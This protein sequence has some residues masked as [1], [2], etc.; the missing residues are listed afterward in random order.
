MIW[1]FT[2]YFLP[3][4]VSAAISSAIAVYSWRYRSSPGS[5]SL[6]FLMTAAAIW[7][8]AYAMELGSAQLSLKLFFTGIEYIGIVSLPLAWLVLS[9]EF[10]GRDS[11]ISYRRI[12][13]LAVIP[14]ITILLVWTNDYHHLIYEKTW[15]DSNFGYPL[16]DFVQGSWYW[17]N[18]VY[19]YALI[20]IATLLVIQSFIQSPRIYKN[21]ALVLLLGAL[22]PW[23]ANLAY[24]MG[25]HVLPFLD[26]TPIAF[27]L[28]GIFAAIGLFH[29]GLLDIMPVAKDMVIENFPEGII[30]LDS[31]NRILDMNRAAQNMTGL[32]LDQS[33]GKPATSLPSDLLARISN[34]LSSEARQAEVYLEHN[35]AEKE[36]DGTKDYSCFSLSLS[37]VYG[38][39]R[40]LKARI[41]LIQDITSR[42]RAETELKESEETA[43]TLLNAPLDA[44]Y[45]LDDRGRILA[46][47]QAGARS[48]GKSP[49]E[50][51]GR[52]AFSL[53]APEVGKRREK[54]LAEVF[55]SG[56]PVHFQDERDGRY[57]DNSYLPILGKNGKVIR[58]GVF[59]KDVTE[60]L[61]AEAEILNKD[62]LL[63]A[64]AVGTN[65]LL[66]EQSLDYAIDQTLEIMGSVTGADSICIFENRDNEDGEQFA[67]LI[68]KWLKDDS[69]CHNNSSNSQ[70]WPY[71]PDMSRWHQMLSSGHPI[72]GSVR[73][74]P[75]SERAMLESK[76]IISLLAIPVLV[77][78]RFWGFISFND[79][80]SERLWTGINASILQA[81]SASLGGA[82]IREQAKNELKEARR[83]AESAAKSK[84]EFLANMSHEIRTPL[85]AVIGL[86]GLLL[87]TD[88]TQEQRDYAHTIR[89]SG[90]SLLS[91]INDILDFSK[92][93]VGKMN[94][95]LQP[96]SLRDCIQ[97]SFDLVDS[98]AGEKGLNLSFKIDRNTP[99]IIISDPTRLRQIL[100][101]LLNN[102]IKFT[103]KGDV[104]LSSFS[105]K[106]NGEGYEIHFAIEDTGIGISQ[107]K[108]SQL[109]KSFS[110]VDPSIT[111]RYGGTGLGLAISK[112][113]VE[114]MGGSIWA[115]SEMGKGSVF[116]FTIIADASAGKQA[117]SS[118][119]VQLP[120]S[121]NS[122]ADRY[123]LRILLAEDNAIN[124]KVALQMLKKIGYE[125]DLAANG[126]EVLSAME[127]QHYDL[128]LMDV[129]MPVMDGIQAA[130]KV[131]ERWKNG[132]KIIAITAYA[133]EG[134]KERCIEAGMDDYI[135]K[136]IQMEELQNKID[137]MHIDQ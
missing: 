134:D 88:L 19:S 89:K 26:T 108:M 12:G 25:W 124:Q 47:S 2:P 10:S 48:L 5:V 132:P 34:L 55:E 128:I 98:T 123:P 113:L 78:N 9:L 54:A 129:Q 69:V 116:H 94:L 110:Q 127:L 49:E 130:R 20:L 79:C 43:L 109:F 121:T 102:A 30:V 38:R 37:P 77:E 60:R 52:Y 86:T 84:S 11:W 17:V 1:L 70:R 133:M 91:V 13:L 73:D 44:A 115:E 105:R 117:A 90:D 83:E 106:C 76:K 35:P 16:I 33:L 46:L 67:A 122:S 8:A 131:R 75:A 4:L 23:I 62:H 125:A 111:R 103:D 93:D 57:F 65:L 135:S 85:N 21:Q 56:Q 42:K 81:F 136:P 118:L 28:T 63:S 107:E 99:E 22:I 126:Q 3:L 59:A 101:N 40:D 100:V 66:T 50:L 39:G 64:I 51:K 31:Q 97:E 72:S 87:K 80:H 24:M 68:Y 104:K 120:V 96:F 18:V 53:F 29:F 82:I 36:G 114:L 45:L 14:V 71:H 74:F 95:E 112:R 15:I 32:E 41:L 92:I 27:I 58:V 119:S 61:Q 7:S 137:S 6:A